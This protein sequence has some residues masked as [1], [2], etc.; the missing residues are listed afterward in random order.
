MISKHVCN[1][2]TYVSLH[3]LSVNDLI[4]SAKTFASVRPHRSEQECTRALFTTCGLFIHKQ[5]P[6]RF[7][8][9]YTNCF[10][11]LIQHDGWVFHSLRSFEW[12]AHE[13]IQLVG[14]DIPPRVGRDVLHRSE[15]FER[16]TKK[17][18][19]NNKITEGR[20]NQSQEQVRKYERA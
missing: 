2:D 8:W 11:R 1:I 7:S 20:K 15:C 9:R 3:P 10:P 17:E 18:R 4:L 14:R 5:R 6:Q 19:R 16:K 13:K 12:Q